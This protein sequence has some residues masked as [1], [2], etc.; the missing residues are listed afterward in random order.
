MAY[1]GPADQARQYFIDMGY[2]PA[3]RQTTADFLVS[4][5]D[6]H[7][8]IKRKASSTSSSSSAASSSS[9]PIPT[10]HIASEFAHYYKNSSISKLNVADME[11]YREEF[12]GKSQI[13]TAYKESA[14][15]EHAKNARLKSPY[16]ISVPMQVKAVMVRRAQIIQ[17]N[18]TAQALSTT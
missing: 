18:Y 9:C 7:G 12:I 3:N 2:E 6:P 15:A 13:A 5:T 8:R 16:T 1:Y 4:V 14:R 17:G 10:P 11:A